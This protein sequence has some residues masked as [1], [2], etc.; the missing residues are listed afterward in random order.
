MYQVLEAGRPAE[1]PNS[2]IWNKSKFKTFI[3]AYNYAQ[4]WLGAYKMPLKLNTPVDYN[5]YGDIIEI[6]K[7]N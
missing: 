7:V 1:Y 6:R 2:S 4:F 3:E 5:G